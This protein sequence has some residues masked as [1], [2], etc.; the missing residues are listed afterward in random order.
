[1]RDKGLPVSGTKPQLIERLLEQQQQLSTPAKNDDSSEQVLVK[2]NGKKR[3]LSPQEE[4]GEGEEGEA[5]SLES[6]RTKLDHTVTTTSTQESVQ[7]QVPT[8][9]NAPRIL[10]ENGNG[11]GREEDIEMENQPST[12]TTTTKTGDDQQTTIETTEKTEK[13][14]ETEQEGVKKE[15][16]EEEE[17]DFQ[18][19][20]QV[21]VEDTKP[22]D[23]Y[24]DTIDRSS[25]DFDFEKLCS[26]TLSH[27]H[28]YS[29]LV[30]GKFFQGRGKKTAAY[31]H[32]IG[33]EDHHVFIN[34]D[35]K[36]VYV[37]PDGYQVKDP[38][39]SDIQYLLSPIFTEQTL[40]EIDNRLSPHYD[41]VNQQP[42]YPGFIG[43]NNIK[44]NSYINSILVSL[45]HVRPLRD[46]F[47]L[48][49]SFE[50]SKIDGETELVKRFSN[51]MKKFWN[52]KLFK[53]QLSPHELLQQ[54]D[55]DS[56]GKFK[57]NESTTTGSGSGGSGGGGGGG[58]P[59]E[60]LS[61]FLNQ[62]HRDLGGNKKRNSS[63]IYSTFQGELRIDDQQVLKSGE[64]GTKPKFDLDREIKSTRSPFLFLSLDLPPPPLFQSHLQNDIIPQIS[65][66]S[67]LSKYN[68]ETTSE[69]LL[70]GEG[71]SELT[72]RRY[73][74]EKLPEF[75]VL[76]VKRFKT[77][78]FKEEEK[79]PTIVNFPLRGLDFK[80]YLQQQEGEEEDSLEKY[81]DLVSNVTHTS[82]A[83]TARTETQWKSYVHLTPARD[84]QGNHLPIQ[85]P[86]QEEG[87]V[88]IVKEEDEKWFEMQDLN[89]M[90][91]EKSLVGLGE[92]YIQVRFFFF[93]F[94]R[95]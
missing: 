19:Q 76:W 47:I 84:I 28:I 6:K 21:Q 43:L 64:Y 57:L 86:G 62:L 26:V 14:V 72:L 37:L 92:S 10:P 31:A 66:T 3:N 7:Q 55:L 60:F 70:G 25:L 54:I 4:G 78:R 75:I 58:D 77:N 33:L 59:G 5:E 94:P 45:A 35:S 67:L 17:Y 93:F 38:S 12:T 68:G 30:C 91:I 89:V 36:E 11:N 50:E 23:M 46:Y 32:S 49:E 16:E 27:N 83:G 56:K 52:P 48:E 13:T 81:Y 80:D 40:K 42:Y 24:L 2:E 87:K 69:L 34:L 29:C 90:E 71:K 61:W 41:L 74:L 22:T 65:L 15:E 95:S 88:R 1:M 44:H 53:P 79:N 9:D 82:L 63:I 18:Q 85:E 8:F 73:K 51:F 39:L 20:L